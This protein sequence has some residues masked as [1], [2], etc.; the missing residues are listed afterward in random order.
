MTIGEIIKQYRETHGLSQRQFAEKCGDITNGYI[1]MIEQGKNPS[2]GKPIVPSIDKVALL[3]RGMGMSLHELI[4]IADDSPVTIGE[5]AE[6]KQKYIGQQ[7]TA[8]SRS[9]EFI[10]IS[11]GLEELEKRHIDLFQ[12]LYKFL[13]TTYPDTFKERI[14]DDDPES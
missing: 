5:S 14:D 11:E 1:S 8:P 6:Y 12:A 10:A 4:E 9:K 3:A 2:T 7:L 13:T